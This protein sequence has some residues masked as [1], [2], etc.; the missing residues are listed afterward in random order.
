MKIA[1][2]ILAAGLG[3]RMK[4]ATAKV[5]HRVAGRP[6]IEYPVA[7]ARAL[8]SE[9][10][11]CVLGHQAEAVQAAVDARFGAG[12]VSIALQ[13]EQRGTGHAVAQAASSLRG[14]DGPVLILYGDVPLLGEAILRRLIDAAR[15]HTLA[16][17]TTLLDDPKGYGRIVRDGHGHLARI[18]E[19]KDADEEQRRIPEINAGIYC[20]DAKFLF[21]SLKKLRTDNAQGELYL[22]DVAAR[23]AKAGQVATI[24][25]EPE[26]VMGVNDRVDLARAD[27]AMRLRVTEGLMRAGVTVRAPATCFIDAGVT[28]GAD[29]EIGPLVELRGATRIG[30][31][32]RIDTG[33]VLTDVT[34]ADGAHLK[35]YTVASESAIGPRAQVGPFAHLR[36]GSVLGAEVKIGNFVETKKARFGAGAKASHLSYLGDAEIGANA[37]IGCGTIT[38]NYDGHDKFR[39][40]IGEGAFIGSDTQLVAPVTVGAG[41]IVGAGTTVVE[42]VPPGALALSRGKQIAVP[43]YADR[44]RAERV[45]QRAVPSSIPKKKGSQHNKP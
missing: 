36:P 24:E 18:V 19:E 37:N 29:S 45:R 38:C 39:T 3:T 26:Q 23:A 30:A 11:V 13:K 12:T 28:V 40:V 2:V 5:L 21:A 31:G 25:A 1:T 7:L 41:A 43:G 35:P 4:S 34:V 20:V 33:C 10:I 14:F 44:K 32:V 42:D 8:K 16:L 22:T 15:R 9:R 27:R 6:M 17:C